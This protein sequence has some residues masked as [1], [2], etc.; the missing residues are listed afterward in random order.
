MQIQLEA[1]PYSSRESSVP[2]IVQNFPIPGNTCLSLPKTPFSGFQPN[3][4]LSHSDRLLSA[5]SLLD[6]AD[7]K[8]VPAVPA[9]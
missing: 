1:Q 3:A 7:F 4:T 5:A 9:E 6:V 8:S 2:I